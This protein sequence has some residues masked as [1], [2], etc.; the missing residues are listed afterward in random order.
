ME[1]NK[2]ICS[3]CDGETIL[4]ET[5]DYYLLPKSPLKAIELDSEVLLIYFLELPL[6][7]E[8]DDKLKEEKS[9]NNKPTT[10]FVLIVP[11]NV[12]VVKLEEGDL[13]KE[14]VKE[15][16]EK[17]SVPAGIR[18]KASL[19]KTMR[20]NKL[21]QLIHDDPLARQC[22]LKPQD[23]EPSDTP[24]KSTR[25]VNVSFPNQPE[26]IDEIKHSNFYESYVGTH[27]VENIKG[28]DNKAQM[29]L[30]F[31]TSTRQST[32]DRRL[33]T[34]FDFLTD[35][36]FSEEKGSE[37]KSSKRKAEVLDSDDLSSQKKSFGSSQKKF[38]TQGNITEKD[39]ELVKMPPLKF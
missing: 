31:K 36:T 15:V 22:Q 1:N 5:K 3:V 26:Y 29:H 14:I 19:K 20:L 17:R 9:E 7:E 8:K 35:V 13:F 39:S 23:L 12:N 24:A 33:K 25:W 2:I 32:I 27:T 6:K 21:E 37:S 30:V 18:L 16:K 11:Q 34:D 10:S 4:E 28:D 38:K